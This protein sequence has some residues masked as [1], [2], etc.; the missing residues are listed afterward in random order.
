M[1]TK[2]VI[3]TVDPIIDHENRPALNRI[4][5][6]QSASVGVGHLK[7]VKPIRNARRIWILGTSIQID[8]LFTCINI[9]IDGTAISGGCKNSPREI[10]GD[11][12]C[13]RKSKYC[14]GNYH[15]QQGKTFLC[16]H[17]LFFGE[18]GLPVYSLLN[19]SDYDQEKAAQAERK[20]E[21]QLITAET[22]KYGKA[23]RFGRGPK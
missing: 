14:R 22:G 7:E 19:F 2:N 12:K 11:Y 20:F 23:R 6:K 1:G 3:G 13:E 8:I 21:A 9:M 5:R 18:I 16:G 17:S 15:G 10:R 4:S